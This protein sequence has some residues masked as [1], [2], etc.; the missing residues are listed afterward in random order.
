MH[1]KI[2]SSAWLLW[3]ATTV[4]QLVVLSRWRRAERTLSI[5]MAGAVAASCVGMMCA[6]F[7]DSLTYFHSFVIAGC[8]TDLLTLAVLFSAFEHLRHRARRNWS[9]WLCWPVTAVVFLAVAL[10]FANRPLH[11]LHGSPWMFAYTSTHIVWTWM[12]WLVS[13]VPIYC[14]FSG[15][16]ASRTYL[17]ILSG[18]ALYIFVQAGVA[19]YLIQGRFA[20][21]S[22]AHAILNYAYFLS[23]VLWFAST[24]STPAERPA[25]HSI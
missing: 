16:N 25:G 14:A 15:A 13:M 5:S 2:S 3:A 8:L 21:S 6:R 4:G 23:L 1:S 18:L 11:D 24:I 12:A 7:A 17:F 9:S 10:R 22:V 20:H 19:D